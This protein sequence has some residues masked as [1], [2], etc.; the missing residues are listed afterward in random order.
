LLCKA[1]PVSVNGGDEIIEMDR[2]RKL[3]CGYMVLQYKLR[4]MQSFIEVDVTNIVKWRKNKNALKEKEKLTN[5]HQYYGGSC[6]QAIKK[7]P[8]KYFC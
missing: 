8:N 3:I 1:A 7:I 4:H 2:M 5:T 6:K